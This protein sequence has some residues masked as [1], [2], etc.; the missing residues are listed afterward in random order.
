MAKHN[1]IGEKGEALAAELLQSKG[2]V[3]LHKNWRYGHKEIDII[4]ASGDLAV[5]AEVKTRSSHQSGFPE[6]AV[7][8][9]KIRFLQEAA[10]VFMESHPFYQRMQFDVITLI[11]SNGKVQE[12]RHLEDLIF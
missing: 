2:Y 6:E 9:R 3:I 4:A 8:I 10:L 1:E 12:I 5:F 7:S 11:L